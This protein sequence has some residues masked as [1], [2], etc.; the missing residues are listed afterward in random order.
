MDTDVEH[1]KNLFL[2]SRIT[3]VWCTSDPP[4]HGKKAY[5]EEGNS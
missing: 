4:Y 2:L 5:T 1:F 3:Q